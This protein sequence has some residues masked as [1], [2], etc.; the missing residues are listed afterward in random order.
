MAHV[1]NFCSRAARL[2]CFSSLQE[3]TEQPPKKR[4]NSAESESG[5]SDSESDDEDKV[6]YRRRFNDLKGYDL[7]DPFVDD[8]ELVKSISPFSCSILFFLFFSVGS[9]RV[10]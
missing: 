9:G 10:C 2:N 8:S 6:Y 5:G 7:N 3:Q 1:L 4:T